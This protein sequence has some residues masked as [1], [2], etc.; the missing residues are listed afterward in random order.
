MPKTS[1]GA[2]GKT[3]RAARA[4]SRR[5]LLKSAAALGAASSL[6]PLTIGSEA[7]AARTELKI[8]TW[9]GYVPDALRKKFK[10][11]TGFRLKTTYFGTNEELLTTIKRTGGLGYDLITPT[12]NRSPQ[13]AP[14][15]LLKPWDMERVPADMIA[16]GLL[17][18]SLD[19]W[20][21]DSKVY[22]LPYLW[23]TEAM[24]WRNDQWSRDYENLSYG[25][26][27]LPEM[28]GKVQGRS[29]S[30]LTGIGLYLDRIGQV[31]SDR[32]RDAYKDEETMRRIWIEIT[33][34]AIE[35]KPWIRQF[36]NDEQSQMA[37]FT[38]NGVVIGQS[39]DGPMLELKKR[40]EPV[41]Y[42]AP[43]EG[44]FAWLDGL[45]IPFGA[46]NPDAAYEFLKI[47]YMPEMGGML[48]NETGYNAVA[49]GAETHFDDDARAAFQ[50][51]YPD[52][53]LEKLWWWPA[54]PE[55]YAAARAEFRDLFLSA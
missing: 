38:E 52:D 46:Q 42:M 27:W 7:R 35:H 36:W 16:P 12:L 43:Q 26:L 44:A 50:E 48:T 14:L 13:W 4:F 10:E 32:M 40:G 3:L 39:W 30:M 55:W 23:G 37:G 31:P 25:D 41:S 33:R 51:A 6:A 29:H 21:W 49:V 47:A 20:T 53:A 18:G 8:M 15:N 19:A 28:Q 45:S 2:A 9:P 54:E 17:Q 22:H 1:T 5:T 34:F 24:A 11:E